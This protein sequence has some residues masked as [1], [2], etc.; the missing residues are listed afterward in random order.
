MH[1]L[2]DNIWHSLK[3]TR[4]FIILCNQHIYLQL[5]PFSTIYSSPSFVHHSRACMKF[6]KL[7]HTNLM[8]CFTSMA[9]RYFATLIYKC[10]FVG[11]VQ[12]SNCACALCFP[13]TLLAAQR[14]VVLWL[15]SCLIV[16]KIYILGDSRPAVDQCR[17]KAGE[18][19]ASK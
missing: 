16:C 19:C 13:Y 6:D 3:K 14:L 7:G 17:D 11:V 10:K 15:Q 9:T 5:L 4:T 12:Y 2:G 1:Q 8:F 18:C